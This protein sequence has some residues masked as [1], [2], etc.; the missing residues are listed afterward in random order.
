MPDW[1]GRPAT[2]IPPEGF[3]LTDAPY[4]SLGE[5]RRPEG[6]GAVEIGVITVLWEPA[7]D[8]DDYPVL[9]Q[10]RIDIEDKY[11]AVQKEAE[12]EHEAAVARAEERLAEA[13]KE[14]EKE[15]G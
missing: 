6:W 15:Y 13:R 10:K 4:P 11:A 12:R 9:D 14:I 5:V 2:R 3:S 8:K 7:T 1:A